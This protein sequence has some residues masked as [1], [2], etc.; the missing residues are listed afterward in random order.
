MG[1]TGTV[2]G[3]VTGWETSVRS[4]STAATSWQLQSESR[5]VNCFVWMGLKRKKQ[6]MEMDKVRIKWK[7]LKSRMKNGASVILTSKLSGMETRFMSHVFVL[8]LVKRPS[9]L[10]WLWERRRG[11][12]RLV[13]SHYLVYAGW[14]IQNEQVRKESVSRKPSPSCLSSFPVCAWTCRGPV[15]FVKRTSHGT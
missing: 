8:A 15:I 13:L 7:T 6:S 9:P 14:T 12:C 2:D 1:G 10:I 5:R 3:R 4:L 11:G